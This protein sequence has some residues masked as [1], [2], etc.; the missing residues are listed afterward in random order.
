IDVA[1]PPDRVRDTFELDSPGFRLGR[2]GERTPMQWS[3]A[4][5]AGFSR[6]EPWLPVAP[7]YKAVNVE[8]LTKD[9]HS[10]LA[11]HRLLLEMRQKEP[12]VAVGA[13]RFVHAD[14]Q[15]FVYER[16]HD[17]RRLLIALNFSDAEIDVALSS[18][19]GGRVLISTAM[20]RNGDAVE[21]RVV[22]RGYEGVVVG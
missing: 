4:E 15:V 12:A 6:H 10:I 3:A 17:G 7:D 19:E 1:I 21:E 20:D 13:Y 8:A 18:G 16:E 5:N 14:D 11:L 9:P 22:L 2:D